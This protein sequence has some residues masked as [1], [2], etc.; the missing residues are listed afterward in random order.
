[1]DLPGLVLVARL[2][3]ARGGPPYALNCA[4]EAAAGGAAEDA[5]EFVCRAWRGDGA[6]GSA[7]GRM[8]G[9]VP[10]GV[11]VDHPDVRAAIAS[12]VCPAARLALARLRASGS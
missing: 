5:Y 9:V 10:S 12:A 2:P 4:T 8:R 3:Q 6:S 7:E 1:P 11:G